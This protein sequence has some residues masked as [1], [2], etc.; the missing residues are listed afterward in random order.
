MFLIDISTS[1]GEMCLAFK[2]SINLGSFFFIKL[3][4]VF[5]FKESLGIAFILSLN[6][7][8][9]SSFNWLNDVPLGKTLLMYSWL[10][11][12]SCLSDEDYGLQ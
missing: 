6:L 11:S 9:I 1:S 12:S 4:G 2:Y 3:Y 8:T 5:P 7:L 10:T